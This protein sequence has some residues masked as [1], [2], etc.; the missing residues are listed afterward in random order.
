LK[1]FSRYSI[2]LCLYL[3][4][5][6]ENLFSF[7]KK[8]SIKGNELLCSVEKKRDDGKTDLQTL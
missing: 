1:A 5:M 3:L 8:F 2:P 6:R 7:Q 4:L